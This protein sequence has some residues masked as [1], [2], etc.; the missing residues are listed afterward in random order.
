VLFDTNV[1][2]DVLLDRQPF[3]A[4][5]AELLSLAERGQLQ[6]YVCATSITTVFYLAAKATDAG[7]ARRLVEELMSIVEI[8]PVGRPTLEAA[9]RSPMSDFEDAVI[10][11]AAHAT[12]CELLV[13]HDSKHFRRCPIPTQTPADALATLRAAR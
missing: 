5:A 10:A 8:A 2:L 9:L 12:G 3:A 1:L 7:T 6:G 11:E 4:S 13:S